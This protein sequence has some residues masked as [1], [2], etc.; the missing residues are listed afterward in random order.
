[1]SEYDSCEKTYVTLRIYSESIPPSVIT[2]RMGIEP[3]SSQSIG[4]PKKFKGRIFPGE[5]KIHG[6]FLCSKE[7]VISRDSRDHLD[8]LEERLNGKMTKLRNLQKK[9]C[10]ADICCLWLQAGAD[11]GPTLSKRQTSFLSKSG[12]DFWYDFYSSESLGT[13]L[14]ASKRSKAKILPTETA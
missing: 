9:G 8:W 1:M 3:S 5:I 14:K 2:S 12:L 10:Q 6:W 11:G 7:F 13:I 4:D